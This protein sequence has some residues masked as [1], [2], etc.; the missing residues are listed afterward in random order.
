MQNKQQPLLYVL[1]SNVVQ[2]S[3]FHSKFY[4][5]HLEQHSEDR[6]PLPSPNSPLKSKFLDLHPHMMNSPLYY[7][8]V[9]LK[10]NR[11]FLRNP[12]N[13]HIQTLRC[14]KDIQAPSGKLSRN[15]CKP[16][17]QCGNVRPTHL[18]T[19]CEIVVTCMC[20]E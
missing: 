11:Q 16:S 7:H 10:S 3:E 9:T 5:N 12:A 8:Q 20:V 1:C 17:K 14:V 19:Q 2:T 6:I 15:T 18:N 4:D 13:I